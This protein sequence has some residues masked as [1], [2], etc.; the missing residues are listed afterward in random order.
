LVATTYLPGA[1]L[2]HLAGR[3]QQPTRRALLD[4][5]G[6]RQQR[7]S[8]IDLLVYLLPPM[9]LF[10]A[11]LFSSLLIPIKSPMTKKYCAISFDL[12][13]LMNF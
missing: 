10:V 9:H 7:G 3:R 13:L 11:R 1:P 12:F 8:T 4:L 2:L 6:R 5:A